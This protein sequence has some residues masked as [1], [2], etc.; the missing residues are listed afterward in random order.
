MSLLFLGTY[1]LLKKKRILKIILKGN[2]HFM[3]RFFPKAVKLFNET[4]GQVVSICIW[5]MNFYLVPNFLGERYCFT[6][7]WFCD[8]E[9]SKSF[10]LILIKF[11]RTLGYY[12]RKLKFKFEKNRIDRIYMHISPKRKVEIN[13]KL[14]YVTPHVIC[15][16]KSHRG[17]WDIS[18]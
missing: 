8:Q 13:I 9:N 17:F 6:R 14:T 7:M 12:K 11:C 3:K 15:I 2:K 10:E 16:H 18:I 1:V 5:S 4:K